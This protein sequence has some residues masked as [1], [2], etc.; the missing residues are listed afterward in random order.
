MKLAKMMK[1]LG[2][3]CFGLLFVSI[4]VL[5]VLAFGVF[6]LSGEYA[7]SELPVPVRYLL[8]VIG[9]FVLASTGLQV[10]ASIVRGLANRAVLAEG[11]SATAEI[12]QVR[13]TGESINDN[14]VVD[15]LLEVR[16]PDRSPFQAEA[17]LIVSRLQIPQFQPG[18]FVQVKYDPDSHAV[19]IM[20]RVPGGIKPTV[21][22]DDW[23][24]DDR[25]LVEREGIDGVAKILSIEDTGRSKDFKPVVRIVYEVSIPQEEPYEISKEIPVPTP[26]IQQLQKV[27]GKRFPARIHPYD[28]YKL[29]I[30]ITF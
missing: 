10:G 23:S 27:I 19:A 7:W 8:L 6:R 11:K 24:E 29:E 20:Q 15:V 3:L 2:W 14:P 5:A 9:F 1:K 18:A 17:Q 16:P 21:Y 30:D 12:V 26:Y 25:A 22:S 28:R 13:D 4:C